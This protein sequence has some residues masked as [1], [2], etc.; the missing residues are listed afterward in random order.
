[1]SGKRVLVT[2]PTGFIGLNLVKTLIN[3]GHQVSALV[4]P[5]SQKS[6]L[7]RLFGAAVTLIEADLQ[8]CE[9]LA[10]AVAG[11]DVVYHLAAVTRAVKLDSFH[12]I[13]IVGFANLLKTAIDAGGKARVVFVSS[14]AAVGPSTPGQPHHEGAPT[15]PISNY[16]KSKRDAEKVAAQYSDRL[17]ISIV[18][19]PIVLGPHDF[20]GVE[21]FRLIDRWGVHFDPAMPN[22]CYSVIHVADLCAALIAIAENGRPMMP[23]DPVAG[24]YFAAGDEI[25]SYRQLGSI[26]GEALERKSTFNLRVPR[27][28]LH[29]IGGFNTLLGHFKGTPQFLNND[30]VRDITAGS[31]SCDN[32]KLKEETGIQFSTSLADRIAQTVRWYRNEGWLEP[33]SARVHQRL[34]AATNPRHGSNGP[35]MNVN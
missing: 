28:F 14:L 20:K 19:P 3:E 4:R 10:C 34:P 1:M 12:Q 29:L 13:N 15:K 23:R 21:M 16:G 11:Q 6:K 26:V 33:K 7:R 24:I 31:W 22:G 30:K 2:G 25:V 5:S 35:T 9:A 8:D 27:P 18:R 32:R 17:S